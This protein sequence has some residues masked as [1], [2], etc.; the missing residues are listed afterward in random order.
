MGLERVSGHRDAGIGNHHEV[1]EVVH[2]HIDVVGH[3]LLV[4]DV[5]DV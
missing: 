2:V 3:E 4:H 5:L 1:L